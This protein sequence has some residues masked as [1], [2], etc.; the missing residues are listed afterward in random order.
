MMQDADEGAE[1]RGELVRAPG[2]MREWVEMLVGQAR[3]DGVALTGE[4]GLLTEIMRHVLVCASALTSG[5][6]TP[7]FASHEVVQTLG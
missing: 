7:S 6:V 2:S 4:G 1:G 5:P 3:E